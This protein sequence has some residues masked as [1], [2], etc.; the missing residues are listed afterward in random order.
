MR[1]AVNTTLDKELYTK[2]QILAIQLTADTGKKVNANDLIEQGMQAIL[3]KYDMF[4]DDI[5]E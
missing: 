4:G 5:L 2:I 3:E 1:T